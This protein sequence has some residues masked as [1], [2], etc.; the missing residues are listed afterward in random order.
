[1]QFSTFAWHNEDNYLY[2]INYNHY[3]AP[4]QV[5]GLVVSC[6]QCQQQCVL[7]Y[8]LRAVNVNT[9]LRVAVSASV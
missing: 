6:K 3:G 1:M 9:L 2:S 7:R 4:K 8:V 5:R